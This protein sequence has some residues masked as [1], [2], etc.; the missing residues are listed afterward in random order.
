MLHIRGLDVEIKSIPILRGVGLS[1]Q[2]GRI[3]GLIGRNGAGKT[4]TL[5]A[6]MGIAPA[7]KGAI[8]FAGRNL[9]DVPVADRPRHGIGYMPE[10]RDLIP[11][12]SV[13]ENILLPAWATFGR[14]RTRTGQRLDYVFGII[15]ELKEMSDRKGH[16]L[17]GGQQ[18]LASLARAMMTGHEL[19]ILDEPF[20]GVAPV[21]AQRILE[22]LSR[23][24]EAGQS[25]LIAQSDHNSLSYL[26]DDQVMIERGETRV[27]ATA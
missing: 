9:L 17:S 7:R 25:A 4:T 18:K 14:D 16:Q 2:K 10:N 23:L 15:P 6:V 11:Q 3:V 24:K 19:L 20:E 12:L 5:R 13:L 22:V 1:V 21:L 26:F 8:E 27:L